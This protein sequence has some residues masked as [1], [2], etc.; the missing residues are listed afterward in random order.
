[1]SEAPN[2][3]PVSISGDGSPNTSE[4]SEN[5]ENSCIPKKV[6]ID[7][8]GDLSLKVWEHGKFGWFQLKVSEPIILVVC[9]RTMSRASPVWKKLLYGG[10][11]ESKQPCESGKAEWL[12][13]LPEDNPRAMTTIL[14]I[15][16][17][18]FKYLPRVSESIGVNDLYE[19]TVLTDKYDLTTILRPWATNWMEAMHKIRDSWSSPP[20][21]ITDLWRHIWIAWEMGDLEHLK[22]TAKQMIL[23]LPEDRLGMVKVGQQTSKPN[24]IG[25][26]QPP[27]LEDVIK[28][29]RLRSINGLLKLFQDIIN[30]LIAYPDTAGYKAVCSSTGY[31]SKDCEAYMLGVLIKSLSRAGLWPIPEA[32]H[33]SQSMDNLRTTLKHLDVRNRF[34]YHSECDPMPDRKTGIDKYIN[35]V[36]VQ[37]AENQLRHMEKQAKKSGLLS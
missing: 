6:I 19:L 24:N 2:V 17:S 11:A 12:V 30:R 23:Y 29:G 22:R 9:S 16:H 21:L 15:I 4:N 26:L 7:P 20:F 28:E 32:S 1:M 18:R 10:F 35:T 27:G 34:P 25:V 36:E 14:N 37:L 3:K 5:S 8:D 31:I 13:E 33:Y